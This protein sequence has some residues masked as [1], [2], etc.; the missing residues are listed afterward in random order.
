VPRNVRTYDHFCVLARTL[1]R[2]GD[3]WSLLVIRDLLSGP[4]R[5]TDLMDRLGGITPKTLTQRLRE[6]EDGGIVE[7]D[8]EAGRREVRYQLTAAGGD[9]APAIEALSWWGWQHAW[10][11]PRLGEALHGEHLLQAIVLFLNRVAIDGDP[12][13]WHVGFSDDGDYAIVRDDECWRLTSGAPPDV[14]A[15]SVRASTAAWTQYVTHP[16]PEHAAD[17][18][19]EVIGTAPAIRR[20]E[21]LVRTFSDAARPGGPDRVTTHRAT[22]DGA[23]P[24]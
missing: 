6:L 18:G 3:R 5:F 13:Y 17:L 11:P 7:V 20:F 15:V 12:A 22:T 21:R 1:E 16:S 10:R 9:L 2:L 19:V 4:K 23:T 24:A 14:P 8:R